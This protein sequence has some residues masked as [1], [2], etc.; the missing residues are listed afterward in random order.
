M[1]TAATSEDQPATSTPTSRIA[2]RNVSV[3]FGGIVALSNVSLD[4]PAGQ[5]RGL[6]GPNGAG[7]TTLFDVMSGVRPPTEG[8]VFIDGKDV[9]STTSLARARA[10]LRRTFQRQQVFSWL[11]VEDNVLA[12]TEWHQGGGGLAGDLFR[13]P[14]R[15]AT[16]RK[17]RKKVEVLLGR[18]GLMSVR[19]VPVGQLP[20]ATVR[21]VELARALIDEPSVLLL[22][23]PTSGL[24]ADDCAKVSEIVQSC[25]D[26][27]GATFVIVEHDIGFVMDL[28]DQITVLQSGAILL[29]GTPQE[30]MD[31]AEV[32]RAYLG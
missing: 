11:S 16:E 31:S 12:A 27:L 1:T 15:T 26:E 7:K 19:D 22:D 32:R 28:C 6:I 20:I 9:T 17:R 8:R 21:L 5:V 2:V 29:D 30:I 14:T 13:L 18:F 4:V 24:Q 3:R 23:E 25:R 10:G